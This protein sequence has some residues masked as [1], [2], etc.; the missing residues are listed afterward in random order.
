M[1]A[2]DL[3]PLL[4]RPALAPSCPAAWVKFEAAYVLDG[5]GEV[6][7]SFTLKL[8]LPDPPYETRYRLNLDD[9]KLLER[10]GVEPTLSANLMATVRPLLAEFE[11]HAAHL[12][13]RLR[14]EVDNPR[15]LAAYL[16]LF[17]DLHGEWQF[18]AANIDLT[19]GGALSSMRFWRCGAGSSRPGMGSVANAETVSEPWASALDSLRI[20]DAQLCDF[21]S[22]AYEALMLLTSAR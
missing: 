16:A 2:L 22:R 9:P 18:H 8:P 1:N 5:Q 13:G 17:Y 6:I 11:V 4:E 14:D 20:W 15:P 19:D 21:V 10:A 12:V 3:L 7:R